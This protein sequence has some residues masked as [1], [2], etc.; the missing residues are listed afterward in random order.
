MSRHRTPGITL[1]AA[2][3]SLAAIGA[4]LLL[5]ADLAAAESTAL[6][7]GLQVAA[8]AC[9]GIL[10]VRLTSFLLVDVALVRSRGKQASKLVRLLVSFVLYCGALMAL[11]H[12]GLGQDI[13]GLLAT[14]A[15]FTA[16]SGFALQA[17]LDNLFSGVSLQLEQPFKHGDVIKVNDTVG[18]VESMTWRALHLRTEEGSRVVLPNS[19]IGHEGVEV[20][21]GDGLV[22][23]VVEVD[24]HPG[25]PPGR[26]AALLAEA[27]TSVA[28]VSDTQ[29]VEVYPAGLREWLGSRIYQIQ[30]YPSDY[31]NF[32]RVESDILRRSW[33]RLRRYGLGVDRRT[34][35]EGT[36][37][38]GEEDPAELS[39]AEILEVLREV[40]LLAALG[41][42]ALEQLATSSQQLLYTE[43][44]CIKDLPDRS[45]AVFVVARGRLVAAAAGLKPGDL[46]MP[47]HADPTLL[48]AW[49]PR[50]VANLT[51]RLAEHLGPV[52][53]I[54]VQQG[55]RTTADPG[56]LTHLLAGEIKNADRRRAF[57]A[58]QPELATWEL[59]RGDVVGAEQLF[60]GE[61]PRLDLVL[62][63]TETTM[64]RLPRAAL[65]AAIGGDL[66][67]ASALSVALEKHLARQ[68]VPPQGPPPEGQDILRVLAG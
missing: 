52:A 38:L 55:I 20:L 60:N 54:L 8:W 3:L 15:I 56:R 64:L 29:L 33:Y 40:P 57:L 46:R 44:D 16:V 31:L 32:E 18:R 63:A 68:P 51:R 34:A 66:A 22:E 53:S 24:A 14:S 28:G 25:A 27:A 9:V 67:Q 17:T 48:Q 7:R 47:V 6:A 2:D 4:V 13:S 19:V 35:R 12:F 62:A 39:G 42:G 37:R 10:A 11:L 58:G 65:C 23:R 5:A 61:D 26:V 45:P 36:T 49:S 1:K 43:D 59:V 30:Y 21:E 50:E 41:H